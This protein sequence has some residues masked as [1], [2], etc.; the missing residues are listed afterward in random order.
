MGNRL[1]SI[2]EIRDYSLGVQNIEQGALSNEH[3]SNKPKIELPTYFSYAETV[4]IKF[5]YHCL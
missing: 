2:V 5:I 4:G 3:L 1:R